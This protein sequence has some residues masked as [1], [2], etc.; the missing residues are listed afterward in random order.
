M[1]YVK[2]RF[3]STYDQGFQQGYYYKDE[4]SRKLQKYDTVIVPTRYGLSLA[5]V[6]RVDVNPTAV[7]QTLN[8]SVMKSVEEKIKSKAVDELTKLK[9]VDDIKRELD[10][11]MK[12]VDE[13]QKYKMYADIDPTVKELL[14][15]LEDMKA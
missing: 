15:Q 3:L 13:V 2:V 1:R 11:R 5:V 4:L 9:K 7:E 12:A 6:E 8:V 10:K 14:Q